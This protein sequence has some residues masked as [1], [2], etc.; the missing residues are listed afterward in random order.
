[1]D[2]AGPFLGKMY[3][4]LI[5]SH[6]KWSKLCK[7]GSQ[8]FHH[9]RKWEMLIPET[10][11][12][13]PCFVSAD[14]ESFLV[15]NGIKHI[16]SAPYHPASNG[17]AE[18]TVQILKRGLKKVTEGSLSTRTAKVLLTYRMTPQSTTGASPAELLLGRQPRT[19]LDLLRPKLEERVHNK[20]WQQKAT[21]DSTAR[22]RE[23]GKGEAV[24]VKKTTTLELDK[25]GWKA[26][27]LSVL[28]LCHFWWKWRMANW[29]DAIKIN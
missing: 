14:F 23:F 22:T 28:A 13:G 4:V 5:D 21:H 29:S 18:R 15:A 12:N 16:T 26:R 8:V 25:C 9:Y 27:L 11:D 1:M 6:S 2:F 10:V 24:Y 7:G 20:Q 3:L 17:L 19:R